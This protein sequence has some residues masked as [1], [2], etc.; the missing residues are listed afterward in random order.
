[1]GNAGES[2]IRM[3]EQLVGEDKW[4]NLTLVTTKWHCSPNPDGEFLRE[5]QLQANNKYWK[6]MCEGPRK[7]SVKRFLG[8]KESALDI[9]RPHL[10][11]DFIPAITE[12]M[13]AP[14]GPHLALGDT[15]AGRVV[16]ESVE[17]RLRS[18]GRSAELEDMYRTLQQKFDDLA[19]QE[20]LRQR[21]EIVKKQQRQRLGRWAFRLVMVGGAITATALAGNSMAGRAIFSAGAAMEQKWKKQKAESKA[22][23]EAHDKGFRGVKQAEQ[24]PATTTDHEPK[25]E[26]VDDLG[27]VL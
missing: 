14:Q 8:T 13:A 20:F 21:E 18:T 19:F 26:E 3:L 27:N 22:I 10:D 6:S 1:M 4:Q 2:N 7:A 5:K 23:L 12:Q 15:A 16:Q 9:I 17:K 25:V 24:L 11:K